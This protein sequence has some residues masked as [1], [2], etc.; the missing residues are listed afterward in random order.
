MISLQRYFLETSFNPNGEAVLFGE[1]YKHI[2][3][4]MRMAIDEKII[5]VAEAEAF[6]TTIKDIT[7]DKVIVQKE[8]ESLPENE[9]PVHITIACG[10]AKGDKHDL[11]VQKGTELGISEVVLF[12]AERSIVKWDDKKGTK[13]IER[14]QKIAHQ[15]AEQCHRTIIPRIESPLTI[16]QLI[17]KGQEFDVCLFADEEAAKREERPRLA[18]RVKNLSPNQNVLIV[19]GPEGGLSRNEAEALQEA[20][21]L[22]VALG[23]RILR[24]ETAPL[25]FLSAVSYEFE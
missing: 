3:Q 2:V 13:R 8:G 18:D 12:K 11:I 15:A 10:L 16:K 9:L 19:F 7:E 20:K 25:Y 1:D 21:F 6:I 5:V 24:T 17:A 23:P 22:P 14:L 4:V